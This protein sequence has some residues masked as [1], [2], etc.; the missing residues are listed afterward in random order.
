M[1]ETILTFLILAV[2]AYFFIK[3][4]ASILKGLLLV[5]LA[6]FLVFVLRDYF[7]SQLNLSFIGN[8]VNV[9]T[10]YL[11][12]KLYGIKIISVYQND[13]IFVTVENSGYLP[14]TDFKVYLD[15]NE[16]KVF[17]KPTI[18]L[19]KKLGVLEIEKKDFK[20][21]RVVSNNAEDKYSR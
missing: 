19:P 8:T 20:I 2:F 13:F 1:I 7:S 5:L 15:G 14:L 3:G 11:L 17:E 10:N 18:L 6:I 12:S 21:L 4:F 16:A 9:S